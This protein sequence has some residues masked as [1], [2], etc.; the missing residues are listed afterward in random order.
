M[1]DIPE[2]ASSFD[3]HETRI[4]VIAG[5]PC[6]GKTTLLRALADRG[7][8]VERETA[9][10]LLEEATQRGLS[11]ENLR[12]DAIPWQE[13][14]L[15]RDF[16]LFNALPSDELVFTD[17][18]FIE[19]LVF[20]HRAGLQEGPNLTRWLQT[21]RYGRVFFLQAL[22]NYVTSD[23][24]IETDVIAE[25]ISREILALYQSFN[26]DVLLVPAGSVEE[27]LAFIE[28]HSKR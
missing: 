22:E 25:H 17:T 4:H 1:F 8:R 27:R 24:R 26:Y 3:V 15:K 5:A 13:E 9:E 18:S 20:S 23:V 6:S 14:L 19:T 11:A 28:R 10:V 16:A 2:P 12:A 7:Y 21:H